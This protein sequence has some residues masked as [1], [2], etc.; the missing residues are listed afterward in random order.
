MATGNSQTKA[1]SE[2]PV[3]DD[4]G[5]WRSDPKQLARHARRRLEGLRSETRET[6]FTT[7][8]ID[9]SPG[10]V[11]QIEDGPAQLE[12]KKKVLVTEFSLEWNVQEDWEASA[13][14]TVLEGPFRLPVETSKP[15][16]RSVQS[17]IVVGPKNEEIHTDE[18]GRVR[19]QFPWDRQGKADEKSSCWLRVANGW[20][21]TGFGMFELP[22][23]GQEVFV[24][25][26]EGD[27]DQPVIVGRGVN[28]RH[29]VPYQLP[30]NK[31]VSAFRSRSTPK[32]EGLNEI[33]FDDKKDSE[34][35]F[36]QSEK[37]LRKSVR[38]DEVMTV[39]HDRQKLVKGESEHTVKQNRF[40][41]TESNRKEKTEKN[42]EVTTSSLDA[43]VVKKG[44]GG[45]AKGSEQLLVGGKYS[46]VAGKNTRTRVDGA[47]HVQHEQERRENVSKNCSL[48]VD[49]SQHLQIKELHAVEAN[50]EVYL[51]SSKKMT[52]EAATD[53]TFKAAGNFVKIDATGVTVKGKL[54]LIN[55][56][57]V[58][59]KGT[60]A[61]PK[62]PKKPKEPDI[63]LKVKELED[64][65]AKSLEP[66]T[67]LSRDKERYEAKAV[68]GRAKDE[69]SD[70]DKKLGKAQADKDKEQELTWI[71]LTFV[72]EE[73][74]PL[75]NEKYVMTLPDG[76][77]RSGTLDKDGKVRVEKLKAGSCTV[78][79]PD[80]KE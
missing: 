1:G 63:A 29:P 17:A 61:H 41:H 72:D 13:T 52:A 62:D 20:A 18:F 6:A 31:T 44:Q 37:N 2:T 14:A 38:R 57:G 12:E 10:T 22:R 45:R 68:K 49:G 46:Q 16:V 11:F 65:A 5:A 50:N 30:K 21:G 73:G 7:N 24:A 47:E 27:P 19:V 15:V 32:G 69:K 80:L 70:L 74:K 35:L 43:A 67:P 42:R 26:L 79:F 23:V 34:L 54:V 33:T 59:G 28:Q 53:I 55:S 51:S 36:E 58:V 77:T 66:V 76:F 48:V 3:A 78:K 25:F 75:A 9:L 71:S 64:V 8:L 40:D 4:R 56:G 60:G 39:G